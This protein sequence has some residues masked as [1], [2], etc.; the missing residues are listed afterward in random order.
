M[1][2]L[3]YESIIDTVPYIHCTDRILK[4]ISVIHYYAIRIS[5]GKK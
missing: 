2:L 1:V 5:N 3:H 4:L